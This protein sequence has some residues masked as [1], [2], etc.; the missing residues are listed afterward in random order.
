MKIIS[1]VPETKNTDGQTQFACAF[2]FMHFVQETRNN[3]KRA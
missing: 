2:S 3:Y 1:A